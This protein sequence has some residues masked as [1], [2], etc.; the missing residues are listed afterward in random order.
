[1]NAPNHTFAQQLWARREDESGGL[2]FEDRSWTWSEVVEESARR[3]LLI[4][5]FRDGGDPV[6]IGVFLENIPDYVFWLGAAALTGSVVVGVNPTRRGGELASDIRHTD[7]SVLVVEARTMPLVQGLEHGIAPER[8]LDVDDRALHER[9]VGF[10]PEE[11]EPEL[12]ADDT[13]FLLL[14][15]SGSTG[16]PKAVICSQGRLG[17]LADALA[18][19]MR[20][21]RDSVTYLCMPLFHGNAVMTNLAPAVRSGATVVL[22]RKFSASGLMPDIRRHGVTYWNYVGRA[23]AYVLATP[24]RPDDRDN[25]L[26]LAYGTEASAADV[27]RFAARFACEVMEGYGASEGGLRINRGPDTPAGSLGLPVG[28]RPME[29]VDEDTLRVCPP[30]RF[31]DTGLLLNPDEAIGQM[32]VRGGAAAFEGYYKNPEAMAERVRGEDFW[33]GDLAYRDAAGFVYFAGRTADWMRVDSENIAAAPIERIL[34]R[35]PVVSQA[36]VY[37]VP[38]PRTGDQVMATVELIPG[39]T[40]DG[41][42]FADFLD[43]QPDLGTKWRPRFIRISAGLP[44]TGN[45]KVARAELRTSG[46]QCSDPVWIRD[47]R[48][49]RYVPLDEQGRDELVEE[50]TSHGRAHLIAAV[51]T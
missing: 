49:R 33:T 15:S 21:V 32:V 34:H 8:V 43:A 25:T 7:C 24:E 26:Q 10:D 50:Y 19:R 37:A 48:S 17:A 42:A 5:E 39:A 20:I 4:E 44:I 45:G 27:E 2:R 22:A 47:G 46:W 38:D 18:D 51:A 29:I 6:H 3:A 28:E 12:P 40:F 11:F 9:L 1:M 23:L 16:A 41:D 35:H 31:D 36:V 13:T 30:A 14:F